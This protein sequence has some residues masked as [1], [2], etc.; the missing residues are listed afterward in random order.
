MRWAGVCTVKATKEQTSPSRH[1]VCMTN[2]IVR[3]HGSD[4]PYGAT[5]SSSSHVAI[6]NIEERCRGDEHEGAI[7]LPRGFGGFGGLGCLLCT[8]SKHLGAKT[9]GLWSQRGCWEGRRWRARQTQCTELLAEMGAKHHGEPL[10]MG[11]TRVWAEACGRLTLLNTPTEQELRD[12]IQDR[13]EQ[14]QGRCGR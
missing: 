6:M 13:E 1:L 3:T 5:A 4:L 8:N 7:L 11:S 10:R 2:D 9:R 12:G 14:Q